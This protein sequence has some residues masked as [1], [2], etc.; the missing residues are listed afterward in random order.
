MGAVSQRAANSA[1]SSGIWTSTFRIRDRFFIASAVTG[2]RARRSQS[3]KAP[4]IRRKW[5]RAD[6][7]R[8][9]GME[10]ACGI[11]APLARHRPWQPRRS[12]YA[13][14]LL[15]RHAVQSRRVIPRAGV[16]PAQGMGAE[17][18]AMA[19]EA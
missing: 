4:T 2:L 8:P 17:A 11:L 3:G 13:A 15:R 19:F 10:G 16:G 7:R 14:A 5:R 12:G 1:R 18:R 6:D 9:G